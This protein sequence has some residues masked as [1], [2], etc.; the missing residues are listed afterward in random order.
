MIESDVNP[1]FKIVSLAKGEVQPING[2]IPFDNIDIE[3]K[4]WPDNKNCIHFNFEFT[5]D[6]KVQKIEKDLCITDGN[7]IKLSSKID[8][9]N[10]RDS[11]SF[12]F[13][14]KTDVP[15]FSIKLW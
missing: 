1:N 10:Y 13:F 7:I 12:F 9:V 11:S 3:I 8:K 5:I 15:R 6:N 4:K 2:Y 14:S